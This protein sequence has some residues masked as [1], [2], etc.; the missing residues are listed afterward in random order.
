[1]YSSP[2]PLLVYSSQEPAKACAEKRKSRPPQA[3]RE[4]G[5]RWGS[6][7]SSDNAPFAHPPLTAALVSEVETLYYLWITF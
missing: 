3:V 5:G 4:R 6:V 2:E 7:V 1:M